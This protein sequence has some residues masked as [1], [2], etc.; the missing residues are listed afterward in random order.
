MSLWQRVVEKVRGTPKPKRPLTQ[1]HIE[2]SKDYPDGPPK[3]H[4]EH[5]DQIGV[6]PGSKV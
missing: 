2:P 1:D 3:N 6:Q 4:T 5:I